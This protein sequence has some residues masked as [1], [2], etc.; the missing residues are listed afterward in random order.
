MA[1]SI[2]L[3]LAVT[4]LAAAVYGVGH[5]PAKPRGLAG[6]AAD[7]DE[8]TAKHTKCPDG[9]VKCGT[10]CCDIADGAACVGSVCCVP[11]HCP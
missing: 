7:V 1:R 8:G 2:K 10:V 3:L 4:A 6:S 5:R 11:P 9:T